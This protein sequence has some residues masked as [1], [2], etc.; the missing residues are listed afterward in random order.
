MSQS[1]VSRVFTPG[2]SV[3]EGTKRKVLLAASELGYRPNA[4]ARS[5]I[6]KKSNI[7]GIV[8]GDINNPFYPEVLS[9][10]SKE[11]KRKGYHVL[12]V[13]AEN[14]KL[15]GDEANQ[16]LEYNV[17]GV[18]VTDALLTTSVESYFKDNNIPI[19][20]FNRY[21]P[22]SFFPAVFCD[23][24]DGGYQIGK[25]LIDRGHRSIAFIS[26]T[27]N[28]STSKDREKGFRNALLESGF[29]L[30]TDDGDYTYEGGYQ[31]ALRLLNCMNRPDAIFCAND[32]MALGAI[33]AA[34]EIGLRIPE[35][36][37]FVGFDDISLAAWSGYSLTTWKQPVNSMIEESV[38]MLLDLID[39]KELD[40]PVYKA[41]KGCLLERKSVA[42]H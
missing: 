11:L 21:K 14:D 27:H 33:D 10:F 38:K 42:Q 35:D 40:I 3:A 17:E 25:Y 7:I 2:A 37:S 24:I 39:H 23:N 36:V 19:V 28:T 26:G 8:M 1:T 20:M 9:K 41:I 13:N 6:T 12:F 15:S 32:I 4:I 30:I 31:A 18:I 22:N 29:N 16:F 34:K 5:L